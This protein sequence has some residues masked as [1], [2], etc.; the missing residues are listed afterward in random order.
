VL[1]AVAKNHRSDDIAILAEC[2]PAKKI[3]CKGKHVGLVAGLRY[4]A[5][6]FRSV[7]PSLD[8]QVSLSRGQRVA[9]I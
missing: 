5:K 8:E 4:T 3:E 2:W 6:T 9:K 7:P 1:L